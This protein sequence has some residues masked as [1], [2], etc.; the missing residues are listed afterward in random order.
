MEVNRVPYDTFRT[1][2]Q[3]YEE[4][5]DMV[6]Y[7]EE[8]TDIYVEKYSMGKSSGVIYEALDMPYIIIAKDSEAVESWLEFTNEAEEN[9]E[10]VLADIESGEMC[11]R[12]RGYIPRV[13]IDIEITGLRPGEKLYEELLLDEENIEV[14][15]RQYCCFPK[16]SK[17]APYCGCT[18]TFLQL[19]LQMRRKKR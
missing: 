13:D 1:M 9:P 5:D 8:N 3:I 17:I 16:T 4:L 7:A 11:I 18:N 19:L 12:D 10:E 2:E 6:T 15:K 14:Y